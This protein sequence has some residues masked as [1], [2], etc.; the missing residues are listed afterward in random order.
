M[1]TKDLEGYTGKLQLGAPFFQVSNNSQE[2]FIVD[3]IVV[4]RGDHAFAEE[5]DRV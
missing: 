4:F 2:L 5:C 3:F 1:V